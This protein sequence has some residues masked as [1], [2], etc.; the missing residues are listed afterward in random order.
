MEAME[1]RFRIFFDGACH[2]CSREMRH[3]KNLP[4]ARHFEY[5]NIASP[6]FRSQDFG[7]DRER[8][9]QE[10]HVMDEAGRI[11][12]G[13]EAFTE[14]WKRLPRWRILARIVQWPVM[15]TLAR[16]GYWT[17]ARLIRP[18]LPKRTQ[19]EI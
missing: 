9:N 2:L 12:A 16:I 4:E 1:S 14:I 15:H 11:Y 5:I 3:Y 10:M 7:L 19:C 8:V 6:Q 17:F 13:V 18:Y